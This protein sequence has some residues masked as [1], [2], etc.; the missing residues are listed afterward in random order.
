[1]SQISLT[2][3]R[4]KAA[5][6]ITNEAIIQN[7][8]NYD[9]NSKEKKKKVDGENYYDAENSEIIEKISKAYALFKEH[10]IPSGFYKEIVDQITSYCVGK[11]IVIENLKDDKIIDVND[12]IYDLYLETRKKGISWLYLYMNRAGQLKYK[13]IDSLEIIAIYD[14]EF[15]DELKEII[16]YYKMM[17]V[18][19]NQEFYRYKV[20]VYDTE[21]VSY[22]MEDEKGEFNF[23]LNVQTNPIFYNT[24]L[25]KVLGKETKVEN[26]GWG[27]VPF[28]PLRNNS[29]DLYDLQVIK[30]YIYLY[31]V[32][33]SGFAN[34]I[35]L[36]QEAILKV[37]DRGAQDW[38]EFWALLKKYKI[39]TCDDVSAVG[40]VDYLKID[41]PY[42]A[43]E[44]FLNIIR[45]NIYEF[46]QAVDT[47]KLGDGNITNVVIK[48]RYA[49]L[50]LK[51]D[52]G[53][54][55]IK[56]FL[57]SLYEFI[58]IYKKIKNQS[59]ENIE[60]LNFIFNKK[61]IFNETE[62]IEGVTKSDGI[63]S[64]KTNIAN[65]P[66][67]TNVDEELEQ[68]KI[69]D[70]QYDDENNED[71]DVN[72]TKNKENIINMNNPDNKEGSI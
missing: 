29:K 16:R 36:F 15:E 2:Y 61:M 58:N 63:I 68:I 54:K 51:A 31:D 67:V 17:V 40:D 10:K 25:F 57:Y 11:E 62:I 37:K 32:L 33:I 8:I 22:Y 7:L 3:E 65:H 1:M 13:V 44:C 70:A 43:R 52:A 27:V 56:K 14:T 18:E 71:E 23:D 21:K 39:I 5:G 38:E 72:N 12:F 4:L 42:E 50:D 24:N 48:S 60:K 69:E 55:E 35:E 41:I 45:D 30:K 53:I 66:F 28:I 19:N 46:A 9:I 59:L 20:E 47:R 34:N 6:N 26:F 64:K 49:N